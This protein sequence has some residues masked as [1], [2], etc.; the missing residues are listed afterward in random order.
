[1]THPKTSRELYTKSLSAVCQ[2]L[3]KSN[4]TDFSWRPPFVRVDFQSRATVKALWVAGSYARGALT[5]GDLD[6]VVEIDWHSTPTALPHQIFKAL[7]LRLKG[8]SVFDGTPASN[9]SHVEFPEAVLIWNEQGR[10]WRSA[11]NAIALDPNAGHFERPTDQIPFRPEQLACNLEQLEKLL[12]L[13]DEGL[14]KW[15]FTP[16]NS[17]PAQE[18]QTSGSIPNLNMFSACGAKTQR[19]LPH[20]LPYF[21]FDKWPASYRRGQE[22]RTKFRLGDSL[23][24]VGRPDVPVSLLN[25]VTTANLL[26]A[27]HLIG[28][29]DSGV[30]RIERGE[31][32]PMTLAAEPLKIWALLRTDDGLLDFYTRSREDTYLDGFSMGL[33]AIDLFTSMENA[34]QWISD[35]LEPGNC[36]LHPVLLTPDALLSCL[37]AVDL[38]SVDMADYALTRPGAAAAQLSEAITSEN[39]LV[40]L[41][42]G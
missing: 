14:I 9:S 20:L 25:S 32:H 2:T 40:V 1:M 16:F 33:P 5:C 24:L 12:T 7:G 29:S 10:D 11:I 41:A 19:L 22:S 18:R 6:V 36:G 42:G 27:P 37:A 23:L 30:W 15:T 26:I 39:L 31:L 17:I 21:H 4:T 38:I 34:Q 3:D 28:G 13:R 35:S 8:V